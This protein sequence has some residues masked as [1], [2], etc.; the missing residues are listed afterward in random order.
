MPRR[1]TIYVDE[2]KLLARIAKFMAD[3][4]ADLNAEADR[5]EAEYHCDRGRYEAWRECCG[6]RTVRDE[7]LKY[8]IKYDL[9][10]FA[11]RDLTPSERIRHQEAIRR[12]SDRGLVIL[13]GDRASRVEITKAG[14]AAL[15][16][17][18][19]A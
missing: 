9:P 3:T 13:Y 14:R 16:Q 17:P 5:L 12:L 15:E 1:R 4:I 10:A 11:G 8:G 6:F 2:M 18:A 19:N 7:I